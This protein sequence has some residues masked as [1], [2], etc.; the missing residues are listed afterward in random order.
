MYFFSSTICITVF[1]RSPVAQDLILPSVCAKRAYPRWFFGRV[2]R[3][4]YRC[5][6]LGDGSKCLRG[7]GL[8]TVCISPTR[9]SD[10][11]LF[12]STV[13]LFQPPWAIVHP[14]STSSSVHMRLFIQG[15]L[16][17]QP[18][19][20]LHRLLF[21]QPSPWGPVQPPLHGL[22][23]DQPSTGSC[24]SSPPPGLVHPPPTGSIGVL[25]IQRQ[26]PLLP[27]GPVHPPPTGNSSSTPPTTLT[28][29]PETTSTSFN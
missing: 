29:H 12:I 5:H 4:P 7:K 10:G 17:I 1:E 28:I 8:K 21:N 16:F 22:L 6:S 11:L 2:G 20:L 19:S 18:P 3:T 26:Q 13:D 27:R 23:F 14:P 9:T 24:S 25:F 15:V